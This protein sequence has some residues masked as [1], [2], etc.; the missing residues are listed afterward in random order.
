MPKQSTYNF[1]ERIML[2]HSYVPKLMLDCL[3]IVVGG[4]LF[5]QRKLWWALIA[6]IGLSILGNIVAWRQDIYKLAKTPLGKWFLYQAKPVNLIV[7]TLGAGVIAVGLWRH[8]A[9]IIVVGAA[10]VYLGRFLSKR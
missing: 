3:G 1:A 4:A 8:S 10:V 6:L 7:R 9:W 5:W 2:Q